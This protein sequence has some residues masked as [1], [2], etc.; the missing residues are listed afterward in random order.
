[1]REI[2]RFRRSAMPDREALGFELGPE[3]AQHG[4]QVDKLG[5]Q[6]V[7]LA[8]RSAISNRI[9]ARLATRAIR[10]PL[11]FVGHAAFSRCQ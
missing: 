10:R 9:S 6:P 3:H 11:G 2:G 4:V 1:M 7:E 5:L 8:S